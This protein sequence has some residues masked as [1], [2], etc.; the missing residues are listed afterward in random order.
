ML[1]GVAGVIWASPAGGG[2]DL[3][4]WRRWASQWELRWV[5]E[6]CDSLQCMHGR[7]II[8]KESWREEASGR[9]I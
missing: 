4:I 7:A 1:Y 3:M 9:G 8:E 2:S 6:Q 5:W